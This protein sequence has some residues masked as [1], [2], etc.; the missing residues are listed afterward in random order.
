M[1]TRGQLTSGCAP[2]TACRELAE[3]PAKKRAIRP[4]EPDEESEALGAP[5]P[6]PAEQPPARS[7]NASQAPIEARSP[8]RIR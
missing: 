2:A 7:A 3:E 8:H 5:T 4:E 6:L 1:S